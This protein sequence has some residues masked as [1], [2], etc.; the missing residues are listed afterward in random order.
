MQVQDALKPAELDQN[1]TSSIFRGKSYS[2][3]DTPETARGEPEGDKIAVFLWPVSSAGLQGCRLGPFLCL[4]GLSMQVL[5]GCD[6]DEV[7]IML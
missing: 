7:R 6:K 3:S 1:K 4:A 2:V 5:Q